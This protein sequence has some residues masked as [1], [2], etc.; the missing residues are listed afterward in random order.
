MITSPAPARRTTGD[1]HPLKRRTHD[2]CTA[3]SSTFRG[4]HHFAARGHAN[5]PRKRTLTD[6]S[7]ALNRTVRRRGST[8]AEASEARDR[9]VHLRSEYDGRLAGSRPAARVLHHIAPARTGIGTR[10]PRGNRMS[11]SRLAQRVARCRREKGLPLY[12]DPR[13]TT[14]AGSPPTLHQHS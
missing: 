7:A 13:H 2:P 11:G 3:A 14:G 9:S 12:A 4:G 6:D 10:D 1:A 5:R 8:P